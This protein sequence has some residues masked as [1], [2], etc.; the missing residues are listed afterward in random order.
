MKYVAS[1][2]NHL[3]DL[4]H[5]ISDIEDPVATLLRDLRTSFADLSKREAA[6]RLLT[7]GPNQVTAHRKRSSPAMLAPQLVHPLALLLWAAA[8]ISLVVGT[9]VLAIAILAVVVLNAGFAFAQEHQTEQAIAA[10]RHMPHNAQ[11][12][13]G[14]HRRVSSRREASSPAISS[15][16]MRAS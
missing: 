10:L 2:P 1:D 13:S 4:S 15:S 3:H 5:G 14:M 6:R 11:R 12:L 7:D 8:L 9:L 16:S